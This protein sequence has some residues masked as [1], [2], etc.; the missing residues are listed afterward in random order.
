LSSYYI[1]IL[2]YYYNDLEQQNKSQ[3]ISKFAGW[4]VGLVCSVFVSQL[5]SVRSSAGLH[6]TFLGFAVGRVLKR[7][8]VS[9]HEDKKEAQSSKL[10]RPPA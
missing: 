1:L 4:W 6:L 7:S 10:A 3:K 8:T 9:Q 2:Q 5:M